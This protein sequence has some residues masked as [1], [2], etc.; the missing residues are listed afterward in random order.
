MNV[1]YIHS[2]S[3]QKV[4]TEFRT[5]YLTMIRKACKKYKVSEK[6][7]AYSNEVLLSKHSQKLQIE[8]I[9]LMI[10]WMKNHHNQMYQIQFI[11]NCK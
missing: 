6:L 5:Y 2:F 3:N 9:L 1:Y 4:Y 8:Q 10:E 7:Y 11:R